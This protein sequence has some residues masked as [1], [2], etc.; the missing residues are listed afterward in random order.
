MELDFWLQRWTENKIGF[1]QLEVN[2]HLKSLLPKMNLAKGS[3]VFVPFCGKSID[4]VWLQRNGFNV[5]G[6][7]IS[8]LA[9]LAFFE[10]NKIQYRIESVDAF[11]VYKAEGIT[12]YQGDFFHLSAKHLFEPAAVYDRASLIALPPPMRKK[13]VSH[14]LEI[15]PQKIRMLLLTIEYNQN[16]MS[17]PP[18]SVPENEVIA[19]YS[20]RFTLNKEVEF[21][22]KQLE[23]RFTSQGLTSM[24]EKIYQLF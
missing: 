5:V 1:N 19:L 9:C 22:L 12:I 13:Y 21:K 16:E 2:P 15:L 4:M 20:K 17:G 6:V 23:E 24:T 11:K 14:M 8:D 18:F 3:F 10:E 7:E